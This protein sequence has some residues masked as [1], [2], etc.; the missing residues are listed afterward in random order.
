M[1]LKM[2]KRILIIII[3]LFLAV[4]LLFTNLT[5]SSD[6]IYYFNDIQVNDYFYYKDKIIIEQDQV[7][8]SN[9]YSNKVTFYFYESAKDSLNNSYRKYKSIYVNTLETYE[10]PTYEELFSKNSDYEGWTVFQVN[11]NM[12]Y[13]EPEG[14]KIGI[15]EEPNENNNYELKAKCLDNT[16]TENISWYTYERINLTSENEVWQSNN[17]YNY[18]S[19]YGTTKNTGSSSLKYTF[20][21][22]EGD[23]L[24]L[25][26]RAAIGNDYSYYLK[27]TYE[28]ILDDKV[29][30]ITTTNYFK[31]VFIPLEEGT[32]TL[33]FKF[34]KY[35]SYFSYMYIK[36]VLILTPVNTGSKL[37][38]DKVTSSNIYYYLECDNYHQDSYTTVNLK[39]EKEEIEEKEEDPNPETKDLIYPIIIIFTSSTIIFLIIKNL[40]RIG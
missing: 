27:D 29:Y 11:N 31:Q 16:T 38:L 12:V 40:K 15:I 39:E 23:Y 4:L 13:L 5:Y 9:L 2:K 32:H 17:E 36:D 24:T 35:Y 8:G 28:I 33:E 10:I 3:L 6:D 26:Y 1:V 19:D 25:K 18:I 30:E 22:K 7:D 37:A 20:T 14:E 34:T 21:S